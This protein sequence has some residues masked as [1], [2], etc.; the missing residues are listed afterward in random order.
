[1]NRIRKIGIYKIENNINGK[2][3]IGQSKDID[4]RV[5]HHFTEAA[6]N[7]K[8]V[9]YNTPLHQAIRKYGSENF[10]VTILEECPRQELDS[11]EIYWIEKCESFDPSSN[12][13]YNL[14]K[15]GKSATAVNFL[16]P[17]LD[18]ITSDLRD[19]MLNQKQI[20]AKYQTSQEMIQGINTGRYWYRDS[21]T[22]PIRNFYIRNPRSADKV[23]QVKKVY[24]DYSAATSIHRCLECGKQVSKYAQRCAKC[25]NKANKHYRDIP[26]DL[27]EKAKE[28]KSKSNL[29]KFYKVSP[30]TLNRW[31]IHENINL[32][33]F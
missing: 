17:K 30:N 31:L 16:Y 10:T 12:K 19:S 25:N 2:V 3:Y 7:D 6:F 27:L 32:K 1:M 29:Q 21:L 4:K 22:Y 8:N 20:A 24:V 33:N 14:T 9:E 26:S 5:K 23:Q 28:L 11:L 18:E 13:G 15:G